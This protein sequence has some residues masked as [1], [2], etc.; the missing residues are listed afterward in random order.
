M[1]RAPD[2]RI[3][4]AKAMYLKGMKLVEIASQLNLPEGTVAVGNLL[5]DGIASARI[6][7]ANVR[8]RKKEAGNREIKMQPALR[9]IRML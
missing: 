5:T 7:K 8:I 9:K 4:Q 1:A 3:E 2:K 6:K